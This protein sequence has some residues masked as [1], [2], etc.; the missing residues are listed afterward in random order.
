MDFDLNEETILL[1]N[2][3]AR[4]LQERC[5][6]SVLRDLIRSEEGYSQAIWKEMADLGWLGLIYDEKY[7][8]I[9]GS[10]FDLCI[11]FEEI[12]KVLLPSPFLCSAVLSG[13]AIYEAGDEKQKEQ[14]LPPIIRGEK[15]YTLALLDEHGSYDAEDPKIEIGETQD[16]AYLVNGTRLLVPYAQVADEIIICGNVTNSENGGPTLFTIDG[17]ADGQTKNPLNTLSEE[18]TCAVVYENVKAS[19]ESIVGTIGKGDIYLNKIVPKAT[20]LKCGE[21]LGGLG[22]VVDMTVTHV[23]ARHPFGRPRG[24]LQAVHHYCADMATYLESTKL[25]TYQAASLLS[26]GIACDKEIAM[27]KAWCNEAYRKS[28]WIAQQVHGGIGFTEEYD[29]H[30]YYK[31][32]KASELTFEGSWF[33]RS[34]VSDEMGL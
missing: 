9:A 17:K 34:N 8:G 18:K 15:I 1:K 20:V 16:D 19:A 12:G 3:A 7:G 13:L 32:A 6:S 33:H 26:E 27:A 4:F 11:L 14:R 30:L 25:I 24:S 29:L 2:N 22:R 23:K 5:P 28:T 31:H 10:F 21:M